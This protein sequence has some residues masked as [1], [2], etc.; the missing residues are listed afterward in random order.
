MSA[1]ELQ[2]LFERERVHAAATSRLD[3][4]LGRLHGMSWADFV[5]LQ[6]LHDAP[7]AAPEP[8]LAAALCVSR[9]RLLVQVR[10]LEKLGLVTRSA[11]EAGRSVG[12]TALGLRMLRE[13]RKTA[14][15]ACLRMAQARG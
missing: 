2:A 3:E 6:H 8:Q 9:S 15:L 5:L 14:A 12:L 4:A 11:Q 13:A 1:V 7:G 10:P